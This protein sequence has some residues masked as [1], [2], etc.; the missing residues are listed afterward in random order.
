MNVDR[1]GWAIVRKRVRSV[2]LAKKRHWSNGL[3]IALEGK[4]DN[5]GF[6]EQESKFLL[7]LREILIII[8]KPLPRA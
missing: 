4:G 6:S 7:I 8:K 1:L 2:V 5:G 3:Y